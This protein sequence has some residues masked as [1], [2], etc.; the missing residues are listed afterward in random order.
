MNPTTEVAEV[1]KNWWSQG[2]S[3]QAFTALSAEGGGGNRAANAIS[4]A[5]MR[6]AT[7]NLGSE[8]QYLTMVCRLA[9]VQTRKQGEVM[10]FYYMACQEPRDGSTLLCN[11]R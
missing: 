10:P 9:S 1:E 3:S 6:K 7:E 11:R 4:V 5:E 8:A 2:G